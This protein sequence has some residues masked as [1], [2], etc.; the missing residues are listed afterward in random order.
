MREGGGILVAPIEDL[1]KTEPVS[2]AAKPDQHCREYDITWEPDAKALAFFSDCAKPGEQV[3]LYLA[4]LD[5]S[6]ARRLTDL[7]GYVHE[8][9]FSPDGAAWPSFM[10]KGRRGL[11]ARWRR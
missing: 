2:A 5:G 9:A 6:P 11:P 7:R 3:D 4:R 1:K 10:W 8:A